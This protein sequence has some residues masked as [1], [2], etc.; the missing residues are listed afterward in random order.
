MGWIKTEAPC[1]ILKY[2]RI[3]DRRS[4]LGNFQQMA[5]ANSLTSSNGVSTS[6]SMASYP[7]ITNTNHSALSSSFELFQRS[8]QRENMPNA[9]ALRNGNERSVG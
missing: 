1:V 2:Q 9:N 5:V 3:E 4:N 6:V 7:S 8:F